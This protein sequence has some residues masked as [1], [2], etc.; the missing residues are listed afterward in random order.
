MA[1]SIRAI[2][3]T[4]SRQRRCR[5]FQSPASRCPDFR[6]EKALQFAG[7]RF[8]AIFFVFCAPAFGQSAPDNNLSQDLL[9]KRIES[10][11]LFTLNAPTALPV[12]KVVIVG[13]PAVCAIQLLNA[14]PAD[15]KADYK[16]RIVKPAS[17]TEG[18]AAPTPQLGLPAC[19]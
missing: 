7:I 12:Q 18:A 5:I 3:A 6:P 19:K 11:N 1:A 16:L 9:K 15:S 8:V 17:P 10:M 2:S 13:K 14:L 4:S